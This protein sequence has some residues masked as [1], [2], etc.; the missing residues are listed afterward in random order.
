MKE[1]DLMLLNGDLN[2][3]NEHAM[4]MIDAL[5]DGTTV[6]L[7]KPTGKKDFDVSE[8]A[9]GKNYCDDT[10]KPAPYDVRFSIIT[11]CL[12]IRTAT[13]EF[14]AKALQFLSYT[15]GS[16]PHDVDDDKDGSCHWE[17]MP[18]E[19]QRTAYEIKMEM[20]N[21]QLKEDPVIAFHEIKDC[22]GC[23]A[24]EFKTSGIVTVADRLT[25]KPYQIS[26]IQL[27]DEFK[28]WHDKCPT[29]L[30]SVEHHAQSCGATPV[31]SHP[32]SQSPHEPASAASSQDVEAAAERHQEVL[33]D[34]ARGK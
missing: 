5:A 26:A 33:A 1:M 29:C 2:P 24:W 19:E 28:G 16:E 8:D 27:R 21:K 22:N 12:G 15:F 32:S 30:S 4:R 9:I 34:L 3:F 10:G 20:F 11:G 25:A 18:T 7:Y 17:I 31:S 13:L 23:P 6:Y 14:H